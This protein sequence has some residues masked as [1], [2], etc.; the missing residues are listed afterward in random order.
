VEIT[1]HFFPRHLVIQAKVTNIPYASGGTSSVF[2]PESFDNNNKQ[3]VL[4]DVAFVVAESS[5]EEAIQPMLQVPIQLLPPKLTGSAWCV[6][7]AMPMAMDGP[8]AQ[9]TC[10]LRYNVESVDGPGMMIP[11]STA[12]NNN[13]SSSAASSRTFVEELQDLEVHAAHFS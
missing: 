9:L 1:K 6:L 8:T 13:P 10:E 7:S 4:S 3:N 5:E 2:T 11:G 12:N